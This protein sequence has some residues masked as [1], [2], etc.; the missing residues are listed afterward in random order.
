MRRLFLAVLT[1]FLAT[2]W[3]M[4]QSSEAR[5]RVEVFGGYTY[6]N[7]D[8]SL[9]NPTGGVSGWNAAV[10]FKVRHHVGFVVDV[11]GFYP[12]FTYGELGGVASASVTGKTYSFLGGPQVSL[13]RGRFT[14]FAQ[15]LMGVS[16]VSA[17]S[18]GGTN[19]D[20]FD[21]NNALTTAAGGGLDYSVK[22]RIALRGQVDWLYTRFSISGGTSGGVN[23]AQNRNVAR[24]STG[25]VFRF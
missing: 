11:S 8:F 9:V 4:A 23:Y 2:G 24:I 14:P 17:Q 13:Q 16:H 20:I 19:Y 10:N 3:L 25:V 21:S 12:S 5:D 22:P 6:M 1:V 15:F 18:I 7:P